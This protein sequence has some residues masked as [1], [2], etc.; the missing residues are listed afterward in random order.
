MEEYLKTLSVDDL[1]D[2][3]LEVRQK[4]HREYCRQQSMKRYQNHP[5]ITCEICGKTFREPN[6][7]AHKKTKYHQRYL[8]LKGLSE[9]DE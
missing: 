3:M 7:K 9:E 4:R 5:Y 1:K 8:K 6:L 2:L